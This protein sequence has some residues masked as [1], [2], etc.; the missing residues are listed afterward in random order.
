[1]KKYSPC[2]VS[3]LILVGTLTICLPTQAKRDRNSLRL[4]YWNIQNGMWDGQ[5]DNY[6]RFV[7]W[8]KAQNPDICIWCEAQSKWKTNTAIHMEKQERYLVDN[9][10]VLARRY[11]HKYIYIG[12][13]HDD[14]PQVITSKYPIHNKARILGN[15]SDTLV[16]HGCGWATVE[17]NGKTLNF[18]T[19]HTWPQ[20]YGYGVK[21]ED[22]QRSSEAHEGDYF[23]RTEMEYILNHTIGLC[24][25]GE[26]ELWMMLGDFNALSPLDNDVYKLPENSSEFLVHNYILKHSPYIDVIKEKHPHQF[27]PTW[28]DGKQRIDFVYATRPLYNMIKTATV[29]WDNYTTPVRNSEKTGGFYF[30]RPADHLPI[31]MDL[32][33]SIQ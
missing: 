7:E 2:I 21:K 16:C 14:F 31:M 24:P 28:A 29:V 26:K 32:D 23:R 9:W 15:K 1:M 10:D 4:L 18:V 20:R 6:N 11:G 17:K 22:R 27:K 30:W 25:H 5:S 3:V 13:H 33:L 8:T 12:G 19:V